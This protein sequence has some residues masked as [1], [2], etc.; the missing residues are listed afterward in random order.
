M[1]NRIRRIYQVIEVAALRWTFEVRIL[2]AAR[3][4]LVALHHEEDDQM[5][6]SQY[7]HFIS[8]AYEEVDVVVL[9]AGG[10]DHVGCLSDQVKLTR[11]LNEEL[12]QAMK[13]IHQFSDQEVEVSRRIT[14]LDTL[15]KKHGEV[16]EKLKENATL[17]SMVQSHD[18]LILEIATETR[19]DRMGDDDDDKGDAAA[20]SPTTVPSTDAAPAA[21][22]PE[23]DVRKKRTRR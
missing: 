1:T 19:L 5:E 8:Q 2:D 7:R 14:E 23:V 17:E 11:A 6:N 18:E 16:V 9:P 12:D 3:Q 4:A 10:H 15:C 20:P 13:D 22:A 21:A